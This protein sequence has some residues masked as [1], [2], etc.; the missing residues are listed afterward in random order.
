MTRIQISPL[1]DPVTWYG[2]NYAGTQVTQWG[3]QN[4]GTRTSLARLSFVLKVPLPNL[5][6]N[7]IYSLPCDRIVQRAYYIS[8]T[9]KDIPKSKT[10]FFFSLKSL[11]NKRQLYVTSQALF[12]ISCFPPFSRSTPPS[13]V[14]SNWPCEN[15]KMQYAQG[16]IVD[17]H[18]GNPSRPRVLR[19]STLLKNELI[20]CYLY[21]LQINRCNIQAT[22]GQCHKMYKKKK[23][24]REEVFSV[25]EFLF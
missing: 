13:F 25:I 22:T 9:E 12:S 24:N 23:I 7:V 15:Y 11:S 14:Q 17:T 6:P 20:T 10:P 18:R 1:H 16:V 21:G 5:R 19:K 3:F 8:E 4:K 2:I